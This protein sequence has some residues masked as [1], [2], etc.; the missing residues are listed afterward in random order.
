MKAGWKAAA[1]AAISAG[2]G[3]GA[4]YT[5]LYQ[6]AMHPEIPKPE[7]GKTRIACVGDSLT[8]GYG[9]MGAFRAYAYPA[10]LQELLGSDYQV[11][12]FG[13]CDRTLC[14]SGDRP[15]R[16]GKMYTAALSSDPDAVV[17]ML[18]TNDAKPHNWNAEE[19]ENDLRN[20]ISAFRNDHAKPYIVLMQPPRAFSVHGKTLD[21]IQNE[22]IRSEIHDIIGRIGSETCCTVIDL[23]SLTENHREWFTDGLHLNHAGTKAVAELLYHT[24]LSKD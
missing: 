5:V 24:I 3:I 17:I 1:A 18:G 20:Y 7:Q 21:D 4:T 12:N 10:V 15:Y 2:A 8:Y 22:V 9:L 11:M 23:Y 6:R 13:F 14:D 19:Y 16:Q